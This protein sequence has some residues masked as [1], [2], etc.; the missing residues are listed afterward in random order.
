[1]FGK[2]MIHAGDHKPRQHDVTLPLFLG[3]TNACFADKSGVHTGAHKLRQFRAAQLWPGARAH[4]WFSG[5]FAPQNLAFLLTDLVFVQVRTS[6]GSFLPRYYDPVLAG[7]QERISEW[8]GVPV[9]FQED[10]Q[11]LRYGQGQEYKPHF[12]GFGRMATVLIYLAGM[13]QS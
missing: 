7:V 6:Y 11:V 10:M 2:T 1:M 5:C 12:D 3:A 8:L 13:F 9:S 4:Q